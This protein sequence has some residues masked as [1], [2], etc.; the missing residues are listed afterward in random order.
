[1]FIKPLNTYEKEK[2]KRIDY[3]KYKIKKYKIIPISILNG[4]YTQYD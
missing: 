4:K 1:M 3:K 2:N